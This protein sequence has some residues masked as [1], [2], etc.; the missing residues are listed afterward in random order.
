M[1]IYAGILAGGV[2]GRM[3][4]DRPKQFMELEGKAVLLHTLERFAAIEEFSVI[5]IAVVE[6]HVEYTRRLITE[7]FG[8]SDRV[9][10][11]PG[12]TDRNG[13]LMNVIAQINRRES[14]AEALLV[15]HDAARPFV[16]TDI[17]REGIAAAMRVGAS[18]TAIPAVDTPL[19]SEDGR[20]VSA[21]PDRAGLY[22]TQTPQTFH[23]NQF[24]AAYS[25]L[26][27]EQRARATDACKVL[28]A[29]GR[30]IAI[31]QG[32]P[33]NIKLTT[34]FDMV[35]AQAILASSASPID[36]PPSK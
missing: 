33:R 2:G 24:A 17:I 27:D 14:G 20:T 30:E 22:N 36:N 28:L 31:V 13:S 10:V 23:V 32:D 25:Q 11:I 19:R 6:S 9:Q 7:N 12:G 3:G 1:N 35:V 16:T 15:S 29:A 4:A 26:S 21:I 34:P 18:N 8:V 5:Y